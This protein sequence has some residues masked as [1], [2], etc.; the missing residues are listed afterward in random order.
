VRRPG[1]GAPRGGGSREMAP[2][3]EAAPGVAHSYL[4]LIDLQHLYRIGV[5]TADVETGP[6]LMKH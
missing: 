4:T 2:Q 3:G 6:K 5:K 1:G